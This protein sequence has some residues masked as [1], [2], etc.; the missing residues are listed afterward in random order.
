MLTANLIGTSSIVTIRRAVFEKVGN[1]N[2]GLN[3]TE[4]IEFLWRCALK[5]INFTYQTRVLVERHKDGES[6]SSRT[7][8]FAPKLLEVFDL[9]E[10][11]LKKNDRYELLG[12]LNRARGRTWLGLL[13]ACAIEGRRVEACKIFP[14]TLRYGFS[15]YAILYMSAALAGPAA[16]RLVQQIRNK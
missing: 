4:D 5:E 2:P 12:P 15:I 3:G 14:Q 16:I 8:L 10:A 11:S 13:H 6:I 7:R 9:F 1:F